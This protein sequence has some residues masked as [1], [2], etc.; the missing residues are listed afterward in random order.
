[1]ATVVKKKRPQSVGAKP[2]ALYLYAISTAAK[3]AVPIL[4]TGID[5][6]QTARGIK[7]GNVTCWI[8]DVDALLFAS[9][10]ERNVDNLDWLAEATL[11]HQR[12]VSEVAALPD[13]TVLPARFGTVFSSVRALEADV[14]ARQA[15]LTQGFKRVSGADEWGV[16]VFVT[17]PRKSIAVD[18]ASGRD[19]LKQ[20]AVIMASP[21]TSAPDAEVTQFS[22]ELEKVARAS[23]NTGKVS[24]AQR[25][26]Q[27]QATFLVPRS[28]RKQ[29]DAVL[30]KYAQLWGDMRSI[31]CTGPWPPYSFVTA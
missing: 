1:M 25:N 30:R 17:A 20:K 23:A 26:L 31:E 11:R 15:E 22:R 13:T 29:W 6:E 3:G 16:K 19:Y 18:A 12:V 8:S 5:G 24:G 28:R 14:K 4:G 2:T 7:L 27:W 21:G 9:E 10:L